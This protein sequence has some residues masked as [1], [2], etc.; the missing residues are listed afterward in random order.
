MSLKSLLGEFKVK[1]L[2]TANPLLSEIKL[3]NAKPLSSKTLK[4]GFRSPNNFND[5]RFT[6]NTIGSYEK[7]SFQSVKSSSIEAESS[8]TSWSC[9]ASPE[10]NSDSSKSS[11]SDV[12]NSSSSSESNLQTDFSLKK[13]PSRTNGIS[14][15]SYSYVRPPIKSSVN[16]RGPRRS[17][18]VS[19][20][21][22]KE[23]FNDS[24][25]FKGRLSL[26]TIITE[27]SNQSTQ[28]R[29]KNLENSYLK[30]AVG[31]ESDEQSP[32]SVKV[33]GL[34]SG[35]YSGMNGKKA[36]KNKKKGTIS[37]ARRRQKIEKE[38]VVSLKED[39]QNGEEKL[40]VYILHLK[41]QLI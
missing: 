22:Q 19:P 30:Q 16:Y 21:K 36:Q 14:P 4:P 29:R 20:S 10:T 11:S 26:C 13:L 2:T 3:K 7:S 25:K 28:A 8:S 15:G 40:K 5:T 9:S 35:D 12:E 18:F 41:D 31:V 6:F 17:V 33:E 34:L 37:D 32:V 38:R 27:E 24:R 1:N 23:G 39:L